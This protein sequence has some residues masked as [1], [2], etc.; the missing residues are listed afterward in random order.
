MTEY[1]LVGPGDA[2]QTIRS[3]VDPSVQTR[4]GWR[5]LPV[6]VTSPPYDAATQVSAGPVV[7]VLADK[8]TRVW[9]VRAKTAQELDDDKAASVEAINLVLL[10]IAFNHE[11]RIRALDGGKPPIT[12]AQF[13]TAVKALL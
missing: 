5:W 10:K 1:A 6:E 2:V 11:N 13:K 4:P 7:S 9:T 8:V 12:L 3:D